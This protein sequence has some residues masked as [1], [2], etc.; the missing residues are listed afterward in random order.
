[1]STATTVSNRAARRHWTRVLA[2]L[3]PDDA[4]PADGA[5]EPGDG[6]LVICRTLD[7]QTS[8]RVRAVTRGDGILLHAVAS[9]AL[10]ACFA[11]RRDARTVVLA[12]PPLADIANALPVLPVPIP[13]D[14]EQARRQHLLATRAALL[15][16]YAAAAADPG[17]L[18]AHEDAMRATAGHYPLAG[19]LVRNP[20]IH[21]TPSDALTF[22]GTVTVN[23]DDAQVSVQVTGSRD[24][25]GV[26][27]I[28]YLADQL[29]AAIG[30]IL[31]E[32]DAPV[33][34]LN[35]RSAPVVSGAGPARSIV[36]CL[37]DHADSDRVALI[38]LDA[39]F[40]YR[41][42]A[43]RVRA[44]ARGLVAEAG[45]G[46]VA[47][48]AGSSAATVTGALAALHAG[49]PYVVVPPDTADNGPLLKERGITVCLEA[50]RQRRPG[51]PPSWTLDQLAERG[52]A[53]DLPAD[54]DEDHIAYFVYTSGSTGAAKAVAVTRANLAHS[55][56]ARRQVYGDEPVTFMMLSP[57]H[58]DSSVA[59]LYGTLTTGGTLHLVSSE[60]LAEPAALAGYTR[61]HR[62]TAT[63]GLP[64]VLQGLVR[65]GSAADLASLR[66]VIGAGEAFP[67][68]L[69][70]VVKEAIPGVRVTNEYGPSEATVWAAWHEVIGDEPTVPIGTPV[71]GTGIAV[72][73]AWRNPLPAGLVGELAISGPQVA[74]GYAGAPE[75]TGA[76]F[77]TIGDGRCYLTGDLGWA[78]PTGTLYYLGRADDEVKVRGVRVALG[79]VAAAFAEHGSVGDAEV[80]I[81][82]GRL[83]AV[84]VPGAGQV[85]EPERVRAAVARGLAAQAVPDRIVV[86]D[87]IPRLPN[88][89]LDRGRLAETAREEPAVAHR[90]PA[91]DVER[92]MLA[93]FATTLGR[94]GLGVDDDFFRAGGDSIKAALLIAQL[95]RQLSTYMYVV[96]LLDHPTPAGLAAYLRET[97]AADLRRVYQERDGDEAEVQASTA[98][99]EAG[100]ALRTLM[101][102]G[103]DPRDTP[104]PAVR[105][106]RTVIVLAPPRSGTTLLRI[107]LGGHPNVF[108]PPE[109]ELLQYGTLAQRREALSG[110]YAFY[111]EGLIRAVMSLRGVDADT[112][113]DFLAQAEVDG[114]TTA[115]MHQWLVDHAGGRVV[116]D[117]T[118]AYALD[119]RALAR[120]EEVFDRPLYIHLTR[121]PRASMAS[122]VQARLDLVYLRTEH[123]F[124]A[125]QTAELV[126]RTSHEQ[127]AAFLDGVEPDRVHRVAFEDMVADPDG[128][129]QAL[130]DFIGVDFDARMLEVHGDREARM[131][132][133]IRDGGRML[134]DIKFHEHRGID[135]SVA[136][137]WR[138]HAGPPPHPLTTATARELGYGPDGPITTA[139]LSS[140]PRWDWLLEMLQPGTSMLN[141]PLVLRGRGDLD[142]AAA[143]RALRSL[144][145]R[146]HAFRSVIVTP[147]GEPLLRFAPN[148]TPVFTTEA[149]PVG[150]QPQ[151]VEQL[152]SVPFDLANDS[153]LRLHVLIDGDAFT[154]LFV[155]HH[156]AT[157]AWS[158]RIVTRDFLT[159][160]DSWRRGE[161]PALPPLSRQPADVAT[162]EAARDRA[163]VSRG[164]AR[165]RARLDGVTWSLAL[166]AGT[167]DTR[168]AEAVALPL[169]PSTTGAIRAYAASR[170]SSLYRTLLAA[171]GVT[172][173]GWTGDEDFCVAT[174]T[175]TRG[176]LDADLVGLFI[177]TAIVRVDMR[178]APSFDALVD[179]VGHAVR[180]AMADAAVP[181]ED[182]V[183]TLADR[184]GRG[185]ALLQV[186]F[187]AQEL[188]LDLDAYCPDLG[189]R[190][191]P[192][193]P[194]QAKF[195]IAMVVSDEHDT[196]TVSA[197]LAAASFR[198]GAAGRLVA[199]FEK[200]VLSL[201]ANPDAPALA[202][203]TA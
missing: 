69:A 52:D 93:L 83:V 118:T 203:G 95:S 65:A 45:T 147:T 91:D 119:P 3:V 146:H 190:H 56:Q 139:P 92:D 199:D 30:G 150:R 151:R 112:A 132:D 55:T 191:V 202:E 77:V 152:A 46:T 28:G 193:E 121:H 143:R 110:R 182:V 175:L 160:Y 76:R 198:P 186:M 11:A 144:A 39:T 41:E 189:L 47:L 165:I 94:D 79:A 37:A 81:D 64:R 19:W 180:D 117:K 105:V 43:A 133:G 2:T 12:V 67:P 42:L 54:I 179:R 78:D 60:H 109:L 178:G 123:P 161:T 57:L 4:W 140:S 70:A 177:T 18:G 138:A 75:L 27:G 21:P 155:M 126:W 7:P 14:R 159:A 44:V 114:W 136:D 59:G 89:K 9:A 168:A 74:A 106:G 135:A 35:H 10:T 13:V 68:H 15:E 58:F 200:T 196:L 157:D 169:A 124:D 51:G 192:L 48:L 120:A 102:A 164:R 85:I 127:I 194:K 26:A 170:N 197:Q 99:A 31:G 181:F 185:G 49:R 87:A 201:I 84:L 62:I 82:G 176:P 8:A 24:L 32:P 184:V 66:L 188:G 174:P 97:Y 20:A 129:A 22:D 73:D 36:D 195:D 149:V 16:A 53:V 17:S 61:A 156:V 72:L 88:G 33:G 128:T 96:A 142:P 63:L 115:A 111:Q 134:G 23:A 108:S 50:T 171:F 154:L 116:V 163:E 71:P 101:T 40:T 173:H 29:V 137:R 158:L 25:F 130:C 1:M 104:P 131:S 162:D 122:F 166:P 145:R 187:S 172:V 100:A 6:P 86:L 5:P 98:T 167:V 38:A 107:M 90:A 80:Y 148:L 125:D 113:G 153:P 34:T 183:A 141:V 103:P